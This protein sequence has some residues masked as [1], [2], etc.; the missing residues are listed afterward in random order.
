M[1]VHVEKC[2]VC[3]K[4]I[5]KHLLPQ[6]MLT[7]T[8]SVRHATT[9]ETL[10][11]CSVCCKSCSKR[12]DLV[13]HM[14][15]HIGEQPFKCGLCAQEFSQRGQFLKHL[16]SPNAKHDFAKPGVVLDQAGLDIKV[17]AT[18]VKQEELLMD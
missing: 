5:Q 10:H 13:E 16:K 6:H 18:V 1:M 17:E 14:L 4:T 15:T 8:H 7:H 11:V 3:G 12:V 2:R 9:G